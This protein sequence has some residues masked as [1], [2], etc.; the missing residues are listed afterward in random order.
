MPRMVVT[1]LT[2][3]T[4]FLLFDRMHHHLTFVQFG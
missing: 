1:L 4:G 2:S 3:K